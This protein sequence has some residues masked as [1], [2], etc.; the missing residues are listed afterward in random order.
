ML[1]YLTTDENV[2]TVKS[3]KAV[4]EKKGEKEGKNKDNK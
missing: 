3:N 1:I 4:K 2:F